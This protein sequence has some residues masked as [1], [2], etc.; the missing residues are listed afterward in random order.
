VHRVEKLGLVFYEVG[1]FDSPQMI[2]YFVAP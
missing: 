2:E 1:P